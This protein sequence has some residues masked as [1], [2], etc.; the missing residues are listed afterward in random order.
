MKK[1]LTILTVF[2]L[3]TIVVN[4]QLLD[5][6][7][8][9]INTGKIIVHGQARLTQ[10][11]IG[12]RVEYVKS[13]NS[14]TQ[15]IPQIVYNELKFGGTSEKMV[16]DPTK[17]LVA[18]T[19]Y[20]AD[21]NSIVLLNLA[22]NIQS[23]GLTVQNG[24]I[25]PS[26]LQGRLILNGDANQSTTG[27]GTFRELELD[28]KQGTN[29]TNGGG[30]KVSTVLELRRGEFHNDAANNFSVGDSATIIRHVGSSLAVEPQFDKHV[31]VH[32]VGDGAM[33][34]GG[35][36]PSDSTKLSNLYVENSG[37]VTLTKHVTVNDTLLVG[38]TIRTEFDDTSKY[39]LTYTS[40][41]D[42]IFGSVNSEIDGSIRRTLLRYDSSKVIFNNPYSYA[43]F[44][45]TSEA[46]NV[47]EITF[48]I[49]PRT[50][51]PML[52]GNTKVQRFI[53]IRAK[54]EQYNDIPN[55]VDFTVGYGFRYDKND[56][57]FDESNK[58]DVNR[59]KLERWIAQGNSWVDL[60]G[61][62]PTTV[63]EVN[64]WVFAEV[65][66][67][68]NFG[69][70][71]I[72]M[73]DGLRNM[74]FASEVL[75][76][77]GMRNR[78]QDMGQELRDSN[79]IPLMPPNIYPYNLDPKRTLYKLAVIPDSAVDWILIELKSSISG[80]K[81]TYVTCFVRRDGKLIDREGKFPINLYSEGVDSGNYYIAVRHRNHL[82]IITEEPVAILPSKNVTLMNFTKPE[83]LLGRADALK[84]LGFRP[85]G[86]LLF[87]MIAGDSNGDGRIDESDNISTWD[88]R[89]YEGYSPR[90]INLNGI[91]LTSDLNIAWNNRG[92][93]T[94]VP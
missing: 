80:G 13:V 18:L 52:N 78:Q 68:Q 1:I 27:T 72:G 41:R 55:G 23:K 89:D 71:S 37:G 10:D 31:N 2:V 49:K 32:Y 90:D 26:L 60:Q 15:T 87:G 63:D 5:G 67:F 59:V 43:L 54:D 51:P 62:Q 19:Q 91:I 8:T 93:K 74:L 28:N 14:Q 64:R 44:K 21:S 36:L 9:I 20:I 7:N 17:K 58:N 75:L 86:S 50:F 25:N 66:N 4:S 61:S 39:V 88:D 82:S 53:S 40:F 81:S 16:S 83:N 73:A 45:S 47:K 33:N 6:R 12:G 69:D 29:V 57:S 38:S 46:P 30:F 76:E 3:I 65:K 85:D 11:T 70:F 79:L 94:Y 35:E 77:G 22:T 84:A 42:P 56:T 92:R 24:I 48:R 34:T